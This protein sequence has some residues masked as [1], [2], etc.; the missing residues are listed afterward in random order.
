MS[1]QTP[2]EI[3][4][5]AARQVD[6]AD[7]ALAQLEERVIADDDTVT[8]EDIEQARG[9]R[10]WAG[11]MRKR[12]EKRAARLREEQLAAERQA[13]LTEAQAILDKH[14]DT[15][16]DAAVKAAGKAMGKLREA[17]RARNEARE[18]ALK[19]LQASPVEPCNPAVGHTR[20]EPLPTYPT[21]G[22]GR[23]YGGAT[24]LWVGGQQYGRLDEDAVM[25][26]ARNQP[27]RLD[28]E[29]AEVARKEGA[30]RLLEADA[31]LYRED[32]AAF[33]ALPALRKKPALEALGH[34]WDEYVQRQEAR[35]A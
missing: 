10:H 5:E 6:Q 31:R 32:R 26:A 25:D 12:A 18:R 22:H 7:A 11:L 15:A 28:A 29:A 2:E 33:D 14:D 9:Q 20:G 23:A 35:R 21:L 34:D 17:V 3:L 4:D 13:A 8:P 19:R 24:V 1:E 27:A 16:V 30:V